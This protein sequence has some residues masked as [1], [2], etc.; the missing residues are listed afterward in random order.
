MSLEANRRLVERIH[1]EVWSQGNAQV[2]REVYS[3]SFAAHYPKWEW[4]GIQEV[5]DLLK[6]WRGSFPDWHERVDDM[7]LTEEKV[8]SRFTS[9]GTHRGVFNGIEPTGRAVEIEEIAIFRIEKGKV[10]EQWGAGDMLGLMRQLGMDLNKR[11]A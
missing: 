2:V 8:V 9:R 6:S 10:I 1:G 7:I 3:P 11:D 5:L 4:G